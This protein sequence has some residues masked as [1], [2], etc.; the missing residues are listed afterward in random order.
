MKSSN[1]KFIIAAIAVTAFS[2][3]YAQGVTGFKQM[4]I[5]D[6]HNFYAAEGC[7]WEVARNLGQQDGWR[8]P[9]HLSVS[10]YASRAR[11][12]GYRQELRRAQPL[13]GR[14]RRTPR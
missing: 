2:T 3:G 9:A 1:I 13:Q 5:G 4:S 11:D 6:F 10:G 8:W 12:V 14:A 7:V